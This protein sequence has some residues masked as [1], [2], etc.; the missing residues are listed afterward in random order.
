MKKY[1]VHYKVW[2]YGT[3][4]G[5]VRQFDKVVEANSP[6]EAE[7]II[8]DTYFDWTIGSWSMG[9]VEEISE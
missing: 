2:S 3:L 5:D 9:I 4:M 6:K 8:K 1:K 7:Q